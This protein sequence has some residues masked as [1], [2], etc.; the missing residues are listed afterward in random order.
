MNLGTQRFHCRSL[1]LVL[2]FA[3]TMFALSA[4]AAVAAAPL[5]CQAPPGTAGIEQYCEAVPAPGGQDSGPRTSPRTSI[6]RPPI[7]MRRTERN[8]R[9]SA[10]GARLAEFATTSAPGARGTHTPRSPD[11]QAR[12]VSKPTSEPTND[13][14]AATAHA[15]SAGKAMGNTF[16]IVLLALSLGVCAVGWVR[17]RRNG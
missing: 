13:P 1:P 3:L 11:D 12:D 17:Y 14:I 5:T 7:L 16:P 6:E 2:A 9:G 8:L 10:D 4:A 15:V